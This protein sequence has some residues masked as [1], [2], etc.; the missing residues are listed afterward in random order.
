MMLKKTLCILAAAALLTASFAGCGNNDA[1]G[2][3]TGQ[4]SS[5]SGASSG[6]SSAES[7]SA[8]S[9][10]QEAS[11]AQP[12]A[13]DYDDPAMRKDDGK[14]AGYQLEKPESGEEIAVIT[15]SE[16]V[17]KIRLFPEAA[18]KTVENFKGLINK[19][20]YD[21]VTFHR[22]VKDFVIQ[23]GDPKG[24]GTGGDS[25]WEE[26][27]EDEFNPNLLNLRGALS[28]AN[29]GNPTTNTSQFFIV[30]SSTKP[31]D[32]ELENY[33]LS[34]YLNGELH[35][36]KLMLAEKQNST[37]DKTELQSYID[38]LNAA[39]DQLQANGVPEDRKEALKKAFEQY[40]SVGGTPNLDYK[41][42][43][44]GQVFEGMDIV[45]KIAAAEVTDNGSGDKTKPVT[46]ITIT[47]AEIVKYEA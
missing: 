14:E 8:G 12:I 20:Y 31:K 47:K 25:I 45:D 23:G 24:T 28:M 16:G 27:F 10:S 40:Q 21:G 36:A 22:V 39:M 38:G 37:T 35:R 44:F 9:S 3:S 43:V 5:S 15:T 4:E 13:I 26:P 30:Q 41:H 33:M 11:S 1:Q 19:G 6:A 29:T 34:V 32:D 42:T 17:V 7:S 46:P 2:A 18:P